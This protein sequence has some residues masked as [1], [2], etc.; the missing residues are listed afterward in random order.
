MYENEIAEKRA[1]QGQEIKRSIYA[2]EA[3]DT[4]GMVGGA[5]GSTKTAVSSLRDRLAERVDGSR[6]ERRRAEKLEELVYLLDKNP[7]IARI[8]DLFEEVGH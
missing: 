2:Q 7:E 5:L 1:A 8:L 6:R 3:C 4:Q